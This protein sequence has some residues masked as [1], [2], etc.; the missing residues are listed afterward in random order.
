MHKH[1][2]P[3]RQSAEGLDLI[4]IRT[5]GYLKPAKSKGYIHPTHGGFPGF[6]P[7]CPVGINGY[8][9]GEEAW[10]FHV[11]IDRFFVNYSTGI[12]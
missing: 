12:E 1:I 5:T 7:T 3:S 6:L 11:A 9:Y 10:K 8:S 2:L 4:S